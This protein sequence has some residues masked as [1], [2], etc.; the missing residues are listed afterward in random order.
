MIGTTAD[1]LAAGLLVRQWWERMSEQ[2]HSE[3]IEKFTVICQLYTLTFTLIILLASLIV[4]TAIHLLVVFPAG[5]LN[6]A[7]AASGWR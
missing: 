7:L 4:L 2:R 3:F 6:H 5:L 1:R